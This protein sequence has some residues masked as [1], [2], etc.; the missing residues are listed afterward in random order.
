MPRKNPRP[1]AKKAREKLKKRMEKGK[2]FERLAVPYRADPH[3]GDGMLLGLM[4]A[5]IF[6][7]GGA[8]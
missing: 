1:A 5:S 6:K 4:A 2:R 7:K 8:A 3:F